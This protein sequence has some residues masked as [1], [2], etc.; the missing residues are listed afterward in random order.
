MRT[1]C[2]TAWCATSFARTPKTR[3]ADMKLPTADKVRYHAAR[4][5][6]VPVLALVVHVA[7][8]SGGADV[9][10]LLQPRAR[11][12]Q[13]IVAP[14]KCVVNKCEDELHGEAEDLA[15]SAKPI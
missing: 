9:A 14:G 3:Q 15:P 6:W 11:A 2:A 7:C 8:A 13:G 12:A 4:W 5:A 10:P 1:S